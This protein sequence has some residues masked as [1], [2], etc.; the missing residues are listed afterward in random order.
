M[1]RKSRVSKNRVGISG[2][3]G[4]AAALA[5][6]PTLFGGGRGVSGDSQVLLE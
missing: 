4:E 2:A 1:P 6:H 5:G 3:G